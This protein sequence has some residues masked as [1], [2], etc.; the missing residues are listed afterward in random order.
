MAEIEVSNVGKIKGFRN[1]PS[2]CIL[3]E[4]Q[5]FCTI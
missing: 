2:E 4:V 1:G 3:V 5:I